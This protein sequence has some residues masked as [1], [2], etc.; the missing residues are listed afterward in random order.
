[1]ETSSG[2]YYGE[3]YQDVQNR[4]PKITNTM[5]E[6]DWKPEFTM[7]QALKGIFDAYKD[8]VMEARSLID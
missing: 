3:G 6:L 7:E 8:Q 4:V 1:L 2:Q 5:A